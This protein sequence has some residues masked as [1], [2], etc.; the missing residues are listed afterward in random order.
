MTL[1]RS[2]TPVLALAL[3]M[4]AGHAPA[5]L[6]QDGPLRITI[7]DGV[8]EPLPFAVPD[9]IAE[10]AGAEELARNIARVVA[11]DLEGTGRSAKSRPKP[12]SAGCPALMRRCPMPTGRRSMP[13]L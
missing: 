9:F 1:L 3:A 13:R 5:A 6:A 10:N 8:I 12:I 4:L 7:T 11:A 2:L